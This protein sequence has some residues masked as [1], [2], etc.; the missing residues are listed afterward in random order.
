MRMKSLQTRYAAVPEGACQFSLPGRARM[1][2]E[3]RDAARRRR[4][5]DREAQ[6]VGHPGMDRHKVDVRVIRQPLA[7]ERQ[8]RHDAELA[9][10]E[11]LARA[12]SRERL[13]R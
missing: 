11:R 3:L 9:V 13:S 6:E 10:E 2:G 7:R 8:H 5:R 4:R 12:G 1:V